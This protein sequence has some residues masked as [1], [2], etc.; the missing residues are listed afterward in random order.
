MLRKLLYDRSKYAKFLVT[1]SRQIWSQN[2][3]VRMKLLGKDCSHWKSL[4]RELL[5]CAYQDLWRI[6]IAYGSWR[7]TLDG[8]QSMSGAHL[9]HLNAFQ[10][11]L[12]F[13]FQTVK[14]WKLVNISG[15]AG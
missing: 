8:S 15:E 13:D 11:V 10:C 2:Y 4:N 7:N 14:K 9:V 12:D 1:K 5:K 6:L 3:Y